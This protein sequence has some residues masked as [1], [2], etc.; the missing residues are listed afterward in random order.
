MNYMPLDHQPDLLE[1]NLVED[2][3]HSDFEA[4]NYLNGRMVTAMSIE[5]SSCES[6]PIYLPVMSLGISILIGIIISVVTLG[7]LDP[8][9]SQGTLVYKIIFGGGTVIGVSIFALGLLGRT[10]YNCYRS[11][12]PIVMGVNS[13]LM[14]V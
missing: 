1:T 11:K 6:S 8:K 4:Q 10:I 14:R 5:E 13:P 3:S 7:F 9:Y 2:L 12:N